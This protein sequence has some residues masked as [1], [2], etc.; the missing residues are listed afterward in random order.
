ML[1][2]LAA[3]SG[4]R[5]ILAG[6][7]SQPDRPKGRGKQL[8]PNPLAACARQHGLRLWQPERPGEDLEQWMREEQVAL[9]VVIAYGHILRRSLLGIPPL[10]FIN[11][12][13]SLLPKYRGASPVE[14][15]IACGERE[16]GI[17]LMK[18]VPQMDAGPVLDYET[19]TIEPGE[20]AGQLRERMAR[21]CVP[22]WSRCAD[23]IL[24]GQAC[25][26][27]QDPERV[28]YC[29]KLEKTDGQLDFHQSAAVLAARI[30]GLDPWPGCF[31]DQGELRIKLREAYADP[32]EHRELPGTVLSADRNGLRIATGEG[33]LRILQ[34]QRPGG[35]MLPARDF[36]SGFTLSPGTVLPSS[37]M[38]TLC[39]QKASNS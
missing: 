5:W 31:F 17:S 20:S 2:H 7:V 26:V 18:I 3:G 12:H 30:N 15:A 8:Q 11:F 39:G 27:E 14:T 28:T 9:V 6:V 13:G 21:A 16:T 10:G 32:E 4:D 36:F 22:L 29:R 34:L 24:S 23:A 1:E 35:R 19:L 38:R 25:F 33:V 37:E